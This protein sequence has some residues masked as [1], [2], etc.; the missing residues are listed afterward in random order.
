MAPHQLKT[1]K[2]ENY[3]R[4]APH[5]VFPG[6]RGYRTPGMAGVTVVT[7]AAP[8]KKPPTTDQ[9]LTARVAALEAT[10]AQ[11]QTEINDLTSRVT[12]LEGG[13][14]VE[15]P[16]DP[17]PDDVSVLLFEDLFP[18]GVLDQSRWFTRYVFTGPDGPGTLDYLNDEWERY[19]ESQNHLLDTNNG[20][21][22][23]A[24]PHNGEFWPSGMIRSKPLFD[25][26]S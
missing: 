11:Q 13:A 26:A 6:E 19:R 17:P 2:P 20:L 3:P 15:P 10:V 12:V 9:E 24:L 14:P 4:N 8:T 16:I 18:Q 25:L 1:P 5:R 22:L 23:N 21:R 7:P